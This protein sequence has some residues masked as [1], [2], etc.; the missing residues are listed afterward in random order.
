[1]LAGNLFGNSEMGNTTMVWN[2]LFAEAGG[3]FFI[4]VSRS[5]SD[6]QKYTKENF[7]RHFVAPLP[8]IQAQLCWWPL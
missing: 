6:L 7:P 5:A 3:S 4:K 2:C 1:M 8:G